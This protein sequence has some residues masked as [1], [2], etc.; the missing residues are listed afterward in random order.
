MQSGS[1]VKTRSVP[2]AAPLPPWATAP[3]ATSPKDLGSPGSERTMAASKEELEGLLLQ[4][5]IKAGPHLS[6]NRKGRIELVPLAD[7]PV[8]IG[9][10]EE[11]RVRLPGSRWFGRIAA[12]LYEEGDV[13]TVRAGSPFWNPIKVGATKV[14]KSRKLNSGAVIVVGELKIRYSAGEQ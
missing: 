5:K 9:H 7:P 12:E 13:W 8:L 2:G 6:L 10:T 4:M 1:T 3:P 14:R 11:C